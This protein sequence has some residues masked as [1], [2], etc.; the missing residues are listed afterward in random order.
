MYEK[1]KDED[2]VR[3]VNETKTGDD[4]DYIGGFKGECF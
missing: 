2:I 3:E 1:L 4:G